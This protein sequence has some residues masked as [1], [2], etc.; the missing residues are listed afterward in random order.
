VVELSGGHLHGSL[1]LIGIGETLA[2][3]R[4]TAEEAPPAFLEIKPACPFGNKNVLEARMV[5]QPG[6]RLQA[7]M[8][9]QIVCDNENVAGRI[10]GF[11]GL[12]QLDVVLGITRSGTSGELFAI[13]DT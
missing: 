7:V 8:A 4:I 6:A 10:V 11:D 13:A 9:A 2:R 5:R 3:Q 12:E 1:D